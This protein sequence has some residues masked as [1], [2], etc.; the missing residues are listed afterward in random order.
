MWIAAEKDDGELFVSV[1]TTQ[2]IAQQEAR[3]IVEGFA[4]YGSA[5][6]GEPIFVTD[7]FLGAISTAVA[8]GRVHCRS[9]SRCQCRGGQGR[10]REAHRGDRSDEPRAAGGC[11]G[12][13]EFVQIGRRRAE[14]PIPMKSLSRQMNKPSKPLRSGSP[15]NVIEGEETY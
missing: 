11:R 15:P 7:E 8:V 13:G 2:P 1:R 4:S 5:S 6:D 10:P 14:N 3:A 12:G 9:A